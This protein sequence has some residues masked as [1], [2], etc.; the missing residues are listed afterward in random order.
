M[1]HPGDT[2]WITCAWDTCERAGYDLYKAIVH[3]HAPGWCGTDEAKHVW[4]TF[5][6]QGHKDYWTN[7][8]RDMGNKPAGSR[9]RLG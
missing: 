2:R 7:S 9:V 5:C 4:Y 6:S 1:D 3:D 8:H